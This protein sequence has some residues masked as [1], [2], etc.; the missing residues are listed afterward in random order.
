M[1]SCSAGVRSAQACRTTCGRKPELSA[2]IAVARTQ[3]DVDTPATTTV[4]TPAVCSV[5]AS[6]VPKNAEAYCL[7]T[8]A[9]PAA[10]SSV[11][12]P[13]SPGASS[14]KQASAGTLRTNSPPSASPGAYRTTV[15]TT[16][17][18]PARAASTSSAVAATAGPAS[19]R[20]ERAVRVGVGAHQVDDEHRRP[21]APPDPA[22]ERRPVRPAHPAQ[23]G[24]F[25]AG[26]P[27]SSSQRASSSSIGGPMSNTGS[28]AGRSARIWSRR[29]SVASASTRA[30]VGH[31]DAVA[32]GALGRDQPA[33]H[34]Q[35]H[36]L[37][38]ALER[39]APPAAA[40]GDEVQDVAG[41]DRHVVA[42]AGQHLAGAVGAVDPLGAARAG[43]PAVD[44]PRVGEPAVVVDGDRARL[45]E[46]VGDVDAV[47]AAV[48]ARRR[49][50]R[51]PS[52]TSRSAAGSRT[53]GTR[54]GC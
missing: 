33:A 6:E 17:C 40:P 12:S 45:L 50:C 2:S 10:G 44:A 53:R 13:Q 28:S 7:T 35:R 20:R 22:G 8:T 21:R 54:T 49:R 15:Q 43:V 42:L 52:P 23:T 39:V 36:Q 37:R 48:Q 16:G 5:E 51:R 24:R 32:L 46:D 9:R 19:G 34:L 29:V 18:P 25:G 14:A 1:F 4:S 27:V 3:P 26:S 47:A 41:R 38:V 30:V 11:S 31:A